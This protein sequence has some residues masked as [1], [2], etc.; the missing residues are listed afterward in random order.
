MIRDHNGLVEPVIDAGRYR[1]TAALTTTAV[2]SKKRNQER[3]ERAE[4]VSPESSGARQ[5]STTGMCRFIP[6]S[7]WM[8]AHRCP[9]FGIRKMIDSAQYP[10][11]HP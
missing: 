3:A 7:I 2:K 1:T 9:S 10:V 5:S 8:A 4:V 11:D 6:Q